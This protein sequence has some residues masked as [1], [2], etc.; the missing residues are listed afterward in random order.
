MAFAVLL[1]DIAPL[2]EG[3]VC[4]ITD[5]IKEFYRLDGI[6]WAERQAFMWV[7]DQLMKRII[8]TYFINP[9]EE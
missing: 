8:F 3:D 7:S 2:K 5:I 9:A 6:V 4:K 1:A